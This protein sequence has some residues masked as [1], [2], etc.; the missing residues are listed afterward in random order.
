[1][2]HQQETLLT[3]EEFEEIHESWGD[4]PTVPS[5]F[6]TLEDDIVDQ[7]RWVTV[8]QKTFSTPAG[9][10]FSYYYETPSTESTEGSETEATVN[11]LFE[12]YPHEVT[13]IVYTT[14]P[15]ESTN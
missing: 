8:H 14:T 3:E 12:V 5:G 7:R 13:K 15:P 2:A 11:D 4:E 1:M 10:F 9:R 6:V